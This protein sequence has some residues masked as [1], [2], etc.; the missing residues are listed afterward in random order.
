MANGHG[1]KRPG[2][3]RPKKPLAEKILEDTT[4]KH[5]AK[6]LD[7]PDDAPELKYPERLEYY[8]TRMAGDPDV[9]E[10]WE[11]TAAWLKRTGCLHLINPA[12]IEE[13]AILKARFYELQRLLTRSTPVYDSTT[14]NGRKKLELN[15]A[16][17]ASL[18][19]LK[20]AD[21]V[22]GKIWAIVA[23]NSEVYF[24]SDP[25]ADVM[26]ALLNMDLE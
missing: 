18:K 9:Q 24:G 4:R 21:A 1:G 6:V 10:V 13:Y 19:Y 25:N 8:S 5:R 26:N 14:E 23:Q 16:I 3:G 2:A 17:D 7:I 11:E 15:P 12:F 20:Q 22:W